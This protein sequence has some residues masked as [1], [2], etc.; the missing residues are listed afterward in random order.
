MDSR[1]AVQLC[2]SHRGTKSSG[3]RNPAVYL[4][5]WVTKNHGSCCQCGRSKPVG[6]RISGSCLP[7]VSIRLPEAMTDAAGM[8]NSSL[9]AVGF[10]ACFPGGSIQE[11]QELL[12]SQENK[13]CGQQEP[14]GLLADTGFWEHSIAAAVSAGNQ[15]FWLTPSVTCGAVRAVSPAY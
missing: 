12:P 10:L 1:R 13:A 14:W 6:S 9:G 5:A 8:G 4:L 2:Y 7:G 11:Q 3:S 15:A